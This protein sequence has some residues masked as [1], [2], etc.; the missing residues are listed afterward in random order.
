MRD[1]RRYAPPVIINQPGGQVNVGN[2]QVNVAQ[3]GA[4]LP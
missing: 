2:Q 3:P 1:L 4:Q